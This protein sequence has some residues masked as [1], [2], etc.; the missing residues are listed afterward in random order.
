M[1]NRRLYPNFDL[2]GLHKPDQEKFCWQLKKMKVH[3]VSWLARTTIRE[4]QRIFLAIAQLTLDN[5]FLT[6]LGGFSN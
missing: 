2:G 3:G 6:L 4:C 5:L 1:S